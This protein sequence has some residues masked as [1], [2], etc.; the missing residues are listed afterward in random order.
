MK[1]LSSKRYVV[2]PPAVS[3]LDR[4]YFAKAVAGRQLTVAASL[5]VLQIRQWTQTS[6]LLVSYHTSA[7]QLHAQQQAKTTQHNILQAVIFINE[8]VEMEN[9]TKINDLKGFFEAG[10]GGR[11]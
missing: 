4:V 9:S 6:V 10:Q 2:L 3:G 1:R 11:G 8:V 5:K 7:L